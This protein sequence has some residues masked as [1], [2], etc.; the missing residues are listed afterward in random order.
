MIVNN[1]TFRDL[2]RKW[3]LLEN[4]KDIKRINRLF[5]LKN[6]KNPILVY[7]YIDHEFGLSLRI[8]GT[9]EVEN[10]EAYLNK[11]LLD[12]RLDIIRYSEMENLEV[13]PILK[14]IIKRIRYTD[15]VEEEM[16]SYYAPYEA[17]LETRN[18]IEID[19]YRDLVIPDNV[20]FL[21]INQDHKK[22]FL[23]GRIDEYDDETKLYKCLLLDDP[24]Q[25]FEVGIGDIVLLKYVN[26][27]NYQGLA[28]IKKI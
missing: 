20:K 19:E 5:R 26:R 18:Q 27:P 7:S 22:E 10:N 24:K 8:L 28:F 1:M 16:D 23:V 2:D 9:I 13:S 4:I 21:I 12:K 6:K 25:E 15:Q 11:K 17:M 14:S 3:F